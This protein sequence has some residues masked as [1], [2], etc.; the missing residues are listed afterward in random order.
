MI[1]RCPLTQSN[2]DSLQEQFRYQ[3]LAKELAAGGAR[4]PSKQGAPG[5]GAQRPA[6]TGES[7]LLILGQLLA[8]AP[9]IL[10]A[11]NDIRDSVVQQGEPPLRRSH[12]AKAAVACGLLLASVL[13][14][15]EEETLNAIVE[16][17]WIKKNGDLMSAILAFVNH[18]A[19]VPSGRSSEWLQQAGALFYDL[20]QRS[21]DQS[22]LSWA[23]GVQVRALLLSG[24][25][26]AGTK[27]AQLKEGTVISGRIYTLENSIKS[28]RRQNEGLSATI[29]DW[30]E[31]LRNEEAAATDAEN[32]LAVLLSADS[33]NTESVLRRHFVRGKKNWTGLLID[34]HIGGSKVANARTA[35]GVPASENVIA[36]FDLTIFGSAKDAV[37]FGS[38]GIYFRTKT[39]P[40]HVTYER[41]RRYAAGMQ[42]SELILSPQ[43]S[44]D[45]G[46]AVSGTFGTS[47][48][49]AALQS[50]QTLFG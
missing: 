45:P 40:G 49:L 41:L 12:L 3:E 6:G 13:T 20:A 15:D 21:G 48:V 43:F 30:E 24:A 32:R 28:I 50:V 34:P 47:A 5:S 14:L 35:C 9:S 36:L 39:A 4:A 44:G 33:S 17:A 37:V 31:R 10:S 18:A 16:Q 27:R 46:F 8:A 26:P 23:R 7:G 25:V 11:L 42:G 29:K 19:F 2:F 38:S 1:Y 22:F